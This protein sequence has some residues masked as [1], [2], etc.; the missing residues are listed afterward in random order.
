MHYTIN[1]AAIGVVADIKGLTLSSQDRDFLQQP[2][3]SGLILF[4]RNYE[5]PQQLA[6]LTASIK[7]LRPD[8]LLC[9]DQEGGRV[10]RFRE[11]F[12]LL[13]AML[14]LEPL[15]LQNKNQALSL[16][17]DLGWLMAA[18]VRQQGVHLSF[19]PVLDIDFG[20]SEVIGNRAFGKNANTV[21]ELAGAFIEGMAEAGMAAVGKHYPG[22]GGV[23]ADSHFDLPVDTR[24]LTELHEDLEPFKQLIQAQKLAGIMPA[25]VLYKAVDPDNNAGFSSLWLQ[26]ILRQNIA[27]DGVIFSDDLTMAAA[28]IGT[29]E[30]RT[31]A[32]IAAGGN[33]L[34]VC[35]DQAAAQLVIEEVRRQQ[36]AG[37]P[38]LD[39]QP[40]QGPQ[41]IFNEERQQEIRARI[42]AL[43]T[44]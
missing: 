19:A 30:Q 15:Y 8:L 13:P 23:V 6:E 42:L 39:L 43:E 32:A 34:L 10:Q 36:Q 21:I 16:S 17:Q 38:H 40:M 4:S 12:T 14:S 35:N 24:T 25:H 2:E 20:R 28:D 11:G 22:H 33:A 26:Q 18:E 44:E 3:L 1:P 27:F 9:V 31:Q 7:A 5:S 29:Y 37:L 41:A